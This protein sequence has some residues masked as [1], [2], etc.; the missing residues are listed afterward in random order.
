[1]SSLSALEKMGRVTSNLLSLEFLLRLF[2]YDAVGPQSQGAQ[3]FDLPVG[4]STPENPLTNYDTLGQLIEKVN[5]VLEKRN[6]PDR[7]DASLVQVRDGFA[8]GR[9]LS[10]FPNGPW[11]LV[12][13]SKPVK[14]TVKVETAFDLTDGWLTGQIKRTFA[15]LEKVHCLGRSLGFTSFKT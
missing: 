3:M 7:I 12:K 11:R 4:S 15:E 13:F 9:V 5:E 6:L 1:M 2:L 10:K 14:G 8:H